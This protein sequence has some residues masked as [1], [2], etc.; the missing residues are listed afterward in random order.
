[1]PQQELA[2]TN[3]RL[4]TKSNSRQRNQIQGVKLHKTWVECRQVDKATAHREA[5][6]PYHLDMV[7]RMFNQVDLVL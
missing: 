3:K 7:Y 2:H 1:M 6:R 5:L 4:S